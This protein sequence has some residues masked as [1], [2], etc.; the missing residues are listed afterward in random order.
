M[1]AAEK[2]DRRYLGRILMPTLLAPDIVE[3][4]LDGR[5]AAELGVHVLREGFPVDWVEQWRALVHP[6]PY[7]V[8]EMSRGSF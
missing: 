6:S 1:A 5:Q 4:I 2:L 8:K 7:P 3:E